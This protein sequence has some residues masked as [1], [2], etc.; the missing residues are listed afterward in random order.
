MLFGR[1]N[2]LGCNNPRAV[3][4]LYRGSLLS[5]SEHIISCFKPSL[6]FISNFLKQH[7]EDS[8]MLAHLRTTI[9][10]PQTSDFSSENN[11]TSLNPK[12]SF[13]DWI[14]DSEHFFMILQHSFHSRPR[15]VTHSFD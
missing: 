5:I 6:L 14:R 11:L 3:N 7:C 9:S 15:H 4:S 13:P 8:M 10:Y 12:P 2:T 1:S